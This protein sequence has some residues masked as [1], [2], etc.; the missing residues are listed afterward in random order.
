MKGFCIDFEMGVELQW[1]RI[2]DSTGIGEGIPQARIF[3]Y[4]TTSPG[5]Y[6]FSHRDD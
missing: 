4:L 5:K 6:A 1:Y 2:S 3:K